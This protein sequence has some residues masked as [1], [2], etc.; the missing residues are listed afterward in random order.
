MNGLAGQVVMA[1][2][3]S[4]TSDAGRGMP[5][6]RWRISASRQ[7]AIVTYSQLVINN[8]SIDMIYVYHVC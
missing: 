2:F 4:I 8:F 3:R 7:F 6:W 5:G 1:Q